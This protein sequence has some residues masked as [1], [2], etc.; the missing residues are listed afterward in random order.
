MMNL[1]QHP[2]RNIHMAAPGLLG[3]LLAASSSV[4]AASS[5]PQRS[6]FAIQEL[7]GLNTSSSVSIH[8]HHQTDHV[9]SASNQQHVYSHAMIAAAHH[10]HHHSHQHP[11]AA[12]FAHPAHQHHSHHG[13]SSSAGNNGQQASQG[14]ELS[15]HHHHHHNSLQAHQALSALSAAAAASYASAAAAAASGNR[16]SA[17]AAYNFTHHHQNFAAAAAAAA[18]MVGD[19]LSSA[20]RM[21]FNPAA[22]AAFL[23]QPTA[24][25]VAAGSIGSVSASAPGA[26]TAVGNS[27]SGV[28]VFPSPDSA[29][30]RSDTNASAEGRGDGG[31]CNSSKLDELN[32]S[33]SNNSG[34][35]GANNP[36]RKKKKKRRTIFTSYQLEELEKAFKEAH[37]PDVYAREMLSLKTDL[38]EDRIQVWF[39]NRRAK[40]RKTEKCWGRSTIM[41]EYGLYGAMVRHSLP[42]PDTIVKSAKENECVA[43]WLLGMHRKSLEAAHQLTSGDESNKEDDEENG[44]GGHG[45]RTRDSGTGPNDGRDHSSGEEQPDKTNREPNGNKH[46][47]KHS[48]GGIQ[49]SGQHQHGHLSHLHPPTS[50]EAS[51]YM[52]SYAAAQ[53]HHARSPVDDFR[54]NSVAELRAKAAEHQARIAGGFSV[55]HHHQQQL[56]LQQ[57]QQQQQRDG[58]FLIS[59]DSSSSSF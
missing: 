21:Y 55:S 51:T 18:A 10:H 22:A 26:S 5:L 3:G 59:S 13:S 58:E 52:A 28:G 56:H 39:Q 27:T 9:A 16:C 11:A 34:V 2:D 49:T 31:H 48:P 43:P 12:M 54:M 20:S 37:Y 40:W 38:P 33:G 46:N 47:S 7:L 6:P 53:L 19:P 17:A 32:V 29:A 41:A 57:Q 36:N 45:E 14:S 8:S 1:L 4:S 30:M 35:N 15:G 25:A 42:L 24:A 23:H 50:N 44:G